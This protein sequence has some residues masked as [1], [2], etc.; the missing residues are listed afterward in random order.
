MDYDEAYDDPEETYY[1]DEFTGGDGVGEERLLV[2]D[3]LDESTIRLD[4]S[5]ELFT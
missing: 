5:A 4:M 2:E 3:G 1:E